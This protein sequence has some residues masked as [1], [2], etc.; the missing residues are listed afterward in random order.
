MTVFVKDLPP[1]EGI[2]GL[3]YAVHQ[4]VDT[5]SGVEVTLTNYGASILSVRTPGRGDGTDAAPVLE[6]IALS[7]KTIKELQEN[8]GPYYGCTAGRVANRIKHGRFEL[9]GNNYYL[10]V[11][12]GENHLHGGSKGFDQVYWKVKALNQS[13]PDSS[14]DSSAGVEY[15]YASADGEEG[16]PG[17]L[18]V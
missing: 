4:L 1:Q 16:Y 17:E 14:G 12:N 6:D 5:E 8:H 9:D 2:D 11:N 18:Q 3:S 13:S 15:S 7:Y 10:A